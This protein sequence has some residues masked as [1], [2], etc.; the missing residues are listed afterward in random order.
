MGVEVIVPLHLGSEK[1]RIIVFGDTEFDS[2]LL[3]GGETISTTSL[4]CYKQHTEQQT[5]LYMN[6]DTHV[7]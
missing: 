6:I 5:I 1:S 4:H 3:V 2:A 7:L